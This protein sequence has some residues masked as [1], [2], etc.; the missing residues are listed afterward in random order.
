M[1]RATLSIIKAYAIPA[2]ITLLA[3]IV[4]YV[5]LSMTKSAY[6]VGFYSPISWASLGIFGV[7]MLW[8]LM[9]SYRVWCWAEGRDVACSCGGML[10]FVRDG[11]RGR[12]D[13][14]KCMACGSNLAVN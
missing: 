9:V 1:Q 4:K 3:F 10:G 12:S 13:Y 11:V 14:R 5:S 7:G 8:S 2:Y 6:L